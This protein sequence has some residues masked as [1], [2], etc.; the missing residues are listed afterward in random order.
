M[1]ETP[2]VTLEHHLVLSDGGCGDK[3][4]HSV[5]LPP[6]PFSI[7]IGSVIGGAAAAYVSGLPVSMESEGVKRHMAQFGTVSAVQ[8]QRWPS[9]RS[10]QTA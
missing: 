5:I 10:K 7:A 2:L 4:E 3:M 1:L 8:I 9:G 6:L